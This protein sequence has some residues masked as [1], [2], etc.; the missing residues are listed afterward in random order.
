MRAVAAIL[1]AASLAAAPAEGTEIERLRDECYGGRSEKPA[2]EL[3]RRL[4]LHQA[5]EGMLARDARAA[6]AA[7]R[8]LLRGGGDE[9]RLVPA[10]VKA[11]EAA[12]DDGRAKACVALLRALS[13]EEAPQEPERA[14]PQ[15]EGAH[16]P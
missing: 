1:A 8:R 6:A 3:E 13:A 16:A 9:R 11:L 4:R 14:A 5:G 10:Y 12:G 15:A 2:S 7:T